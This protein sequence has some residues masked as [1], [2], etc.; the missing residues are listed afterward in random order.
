MPGT[1][2]SLA[3]RAET[4]ELHPLTQGEI[5]GRPEDFLDR[6]FAGD[7]LLGRSSTLTRADYVTASVAGGFPEARRRPGRTRHA[8]SSRT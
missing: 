8:W 6:L 5:R 2:D 3:G 7:L 1:G 4:I